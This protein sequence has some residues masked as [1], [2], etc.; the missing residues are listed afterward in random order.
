M[1]LR[2]IM[3]S[4]VANLLAAAKQTALQA[5]ARARPHDEYW[6]G[7]LDGLAAV[8]AAFGLTMTQPV[9][10]IEMPSSTLTREA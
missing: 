9:D 10:V 2:I 4:D 8:G 5:R 7:Y 1:A 6:Q 3:L